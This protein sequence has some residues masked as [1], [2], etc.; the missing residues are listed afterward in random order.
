MVCLT[1]N[2]RRRCASIGEGSGYDHS[3]SY[4]EL[5]KPFFGTT[6][7]VILYDNNVL[8]NNNNNNCTEDDYDE[9]YMDTCT[10]DEDYDEKYID[11]Y[12]NLPTRADDLHDSQQDF[13]Y[14]SRSPY[15]DIASPRSV[16]SFDDDADIQ[17]CYE[18]RGAS[19]TP[20]PYMDM[21]YSLDKR[22]NADDDYGEY[23]NRSA[24]DTEDNRMDGYEREQD[25]YQNQRSYFSDDELREPLYSKYNE[26]SRYFTSDDE[27]L[28]QDAL[29]S[30]Q[31][32]SGYERGYTSNE[33]SVDHSDYNEHDYQYLDDIA[34][35]DIYTTTFEFDRIVC[36]GFRSFPSHF[37]RLPQ[38][39]TNSNNW[40]NTNGDIEA[41]SEVQR[42]DDCNVDTSVSP[43]VTITGQISKNRDPRLNRDLNK[44]N[45]N[46][47]VVDVVSEQTSHEPKVKDTSERKGTNYVTMH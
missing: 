8:T 5:R 44:S 31:N 33:E 43:E 10:D 4:M 14:T 26:K 22:M 9:K 18:G 6:E 17:D 16:S 39:Y 27:E 20:E 42:S 11:A 25:S 24:S 35:D 32:V 47:A 38:I 45:Y 3:P 29:S 1:E 2:S 19:I 46:G 21:T 41:S 12:P 23:E 34:K 30:I 40:S 15:E 13:Y 28:V 7:D 36:D 37:L